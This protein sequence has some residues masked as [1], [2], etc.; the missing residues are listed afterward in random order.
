MTLG[1]A[2]HWRLQGLALPAEAAVRRD[3]VWPP[4]L[5]PPG[6]ADAYDGRT[7]AYAAARLPGGRGAVLCCP[8]LFNLWPVL[9]A[10]LPP[11]ARRRRFASS[12]AVF[13]PG[14]HGRLGMQL[15]GGPAELPVG[16]DLSGIFA[17]RNVL[18]TMSRDNPPDWVL[19]WVRFHAR[20]HGADAVAIFD[21]GS[22]RYPAA[23]I[24]PRLADI[25]GIGPVAVIEADF[26][27]GPQLPR[28][29]GQVSHFLQGACLNLARLTVLARARAVL[30]LDVDELLRP[31]SGQSVFDAAAASPLGHAKLGGT[32]VYPEEGLPW[33]QPQRAHVFRAVPREPCHLK[34]CATPRGLLSRAGWEVHK[35][36][37]PLTKRLRP[38]PGFELLHCRAA[39][40]GWKRPLCGAPETRRRADPELA[41]LWP[42][43]G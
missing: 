3:P 31:V 18:L 32:W 20:L 2:V 9:R 19:D 14:S 16:P 39:T 28:R 37:A 7:L 27:Y 36:A 5:Q 4:D 11:G 43:E 23:G 24:A 6:Y 21:N 25:P 40:T 17:G 30:N 8:R 10:A 34:W 42:P 22:V 15:P 38:H 13:L 29:R 1:Q 12:E 26:P 41:G 33:P 35:L